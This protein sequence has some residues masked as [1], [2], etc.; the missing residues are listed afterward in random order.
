MHLLTPEVE[1]VH[2]HPQHHRM[3]AVE[4]VTAARIVGVF[5]VVVEDVVGL[6][7][8][9]AKREDGTIIAPLGGVVVDHIQDHLDIGA[10]QRLDHV[11]KLGERIIAAGVLRVRGEKG[12]G[13]VTPVVGE[14][15]WCILGIELE[16]RQQ[17]DGGDAEG[18]QVGDLLDKPEIGAAQRRINPRAG[19]FGKPP[20]MQLI[21][22]RAG[23]RVGGQ[24]V[25]FPVVV[26]GIDH[27]ILGA[28]GQIA[29]WPGR[30]PSVVVGAQLD[31][32]TIGIEQYL[33]GIEAGAAVRA[34]WALNPIGVAL[35]DR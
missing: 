27:P 22:H 23:E 9:A 6:V 17:L 11:A 10:V 35:T 24:L 18:L 13:A 7:I 3:G 14:P 19:G 8:D 15:L 1:A 31:A 4:G 21:D 12:H 30:R 2:D 29:A 32:A 20:Q 26:T 5:L 33:L 16:H 28:A 25:P 34:P